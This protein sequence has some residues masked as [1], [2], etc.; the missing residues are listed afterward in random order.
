MYVVIYGANP[1]IPVAVRSFTHPLDCRPFKI[2]RVAC[3]CFSCR[4]R[5]AYRARSFA[6]LR[7]Y[8][9][10]E[11]FFQF[12]HGIIRSVRSIRLFVPPAATE[13]C[14][15]TRLLRSSA[16][17]DGRRIHSSARTCFHRRFGRKRLETAAC[18]RGWYTSRREWGWGGG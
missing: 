12:V 10:K 17:S 1:S 14:V 11:S 15:F 3:V 9:L 4:M 8:R 7:S 6:V 5:Y 2:N 13:Y 16:C 18:R